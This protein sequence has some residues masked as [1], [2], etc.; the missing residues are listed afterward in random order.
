MP[1]PD[2]QGHHISVDNNHAYL[3]DN[4]AGI[5]IINLTDLAKNTTNIAK[6]T[7]ETALELNSVNFGYMVDISV[8]NNYAYVTIGGSRYFVVFNLDDPLNTASHIHFA[9]D[10]PKGI[11]IDEQRDLAYIANNAAGLTIVDISNV[12]N[13]TRMQTVPLCTTGYAETVT[14]KD[15]IAYL[16]YGGSGNTVYNG[17]VCVYNVSTRGDATFLS[18]VQLKT[19]TSN[20]FLRDIGGSRYLFGVGGSQLTIVDV[21]NS[22]SNVSCAQGVSTDSRCKSYWSHDYSHLTGVHVTCDHVYL[23]LSTTSNT[24]SISGLAVLN[25]ANLEA[26]PSSYTIQQTLGNAQSVQ[27]V[28]NVAY[29]ADSEYGLAIIAVP[30]PTNLCSASYKNT[31]AL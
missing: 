16:T 15:H 28:N 1:A 7:L 2:A 21:T 18:Q 30:D 10:E 8:R 4:N 22:T 29:M 24:D 27:V 23:S 19:Y 5:A 17:G 13:L 3:I 11:F 26:P 31:Y 9:H 20:M 12:T 25:V 6:T 14:V